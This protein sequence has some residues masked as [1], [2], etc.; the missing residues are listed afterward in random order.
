MFLLTNHNCS[1]QQ[2]TQDTAQCAC[3]E[4]V[5]GL[6][7]FDGTVACWEVSL[8]IKMAKSPQ[9]K[10]SQPLACFVHTVSDQRVGLWLRGCCCFPMQIAGEDHQ[11]DSREWYELLHVVCVCKFTDRSTEHAI[12]QGDSVFLVRP[13]LDHCCLVD[14]T[15][16]SSGQYSLSINFSPMFKRMF[17][18]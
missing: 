5:S 9:N 12:G 3:K 18:F 15:F 2:K 13:L 16:S 14:C 11:A 1:G 7:C 8:G 6:T 10:R 4:L 17:T